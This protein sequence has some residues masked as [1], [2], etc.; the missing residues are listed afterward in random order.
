MATADA[1]DL[2]FL[3]ERI[4]PKKPFKLALVTARWNWEVTGK[5]LEGAEKYLA[6]CGLQNIVQHQ[7]PGSYELTFAAAKLASQE[8]IDAV[9]CLGCVVKGETPHFDFICEAVAHG[10]ANV[11]IKYTK[12]VAFGVLTTYTMEQALE[13]AGGKL[14]NKGAE[15]AATVL[16]LLNEFN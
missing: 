11:S 7:V 1:Q 2:G 13:R 3:Y 5:L 12:P 4:N 15:A 9:I 8:G 10:I 6:S 14:G 16:A